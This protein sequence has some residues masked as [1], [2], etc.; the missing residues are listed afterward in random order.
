MRKWLAKC[1]CGQDRANP[2]P[3]L[4]DLSGPSG[5]LSHT[6]AGSRYQVGGTSQYG[7]VTSMAP[8]HV[9]SI[10]FGDSR[11]AAGGPHSEGRA[12]GFLSW[13][14]LFCKRKGK[15]KKNTQHKIINVFL[16]E[17]HWAGLREDATI[18]PA[19][20]F[21]V[22]FRPSGAAAAPEAPGTDPVRT[23]AQV[24]Q[25]ISPGDQI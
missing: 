7:L 20:G 5:P 2:E 14:F 16:F 8:N 11:W 19:P 17:Y 1:F 18:N 6:S 9:N 22:D 12:A 15:Q 21:S 3:K 23:R 4:S 25:Q 24:A 13:R 10:W